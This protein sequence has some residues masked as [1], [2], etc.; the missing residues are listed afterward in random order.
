MVGDSSGSGVIISADGL[1]LTA[2]HVAVKAGMPVTFTF[3]NGHTAHGK[4]LGVNEDVDTGLMKITDAGNWSH[5][6]IG[7]V[8]SA[9][10]GDWVLAMGNPGGF[11]L[12]RSLV[13]RL[14]RIIQIA[15]EQLQTDCTI[16]PGDSGGPLF[17]MHGRVIGIH[18]S[19]ANA[20]AD[21]FHVPISQFSETWD[22]L[23]G[24]TH[25]PVTY[26]GLSIIE[27]DSG[28]RVDKVE[29]NSPAA[30]ASLRKDDRILAVNGRRVEFAETF[31][32]WMAKSRPGDV[33][34]LEVLRGKKIMPKSITMQPMPTMPTAK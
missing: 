33:L 24:V 29:K 15:P 11:D 26:C 31:E 10:P 25:R 6:S 4:T 7:D 2:G 1:V 5:A 21:N 34:E 30:K 20:A 16:F 18:T 27:D 17:D 22:E 28:C 8:A 9:R 14:G 32:H 3:P 13:T 19:I 12:K 23:S